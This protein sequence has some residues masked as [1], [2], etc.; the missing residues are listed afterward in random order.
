MPTKKEIREAQCLIDSGKAWLYEGSV[1]RACINLIEMGCCKLGK[2]GH[3]DSY[4]NYVPSRFQVK[5]GA[6]GSVDFCDKM[7]CEM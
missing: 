2:V 7:Q 1:G 6:E 5:A 4:G 3:Y